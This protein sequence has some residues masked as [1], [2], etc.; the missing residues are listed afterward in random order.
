MGMKKLNQ[1]YEK[2]SMHRGLF[3]RLKD[4]WNSESNA[5]PLP[6]KSAAPAMPP[7][8][9]KQPEGEI[10]MGK[11]IVGGLIGGALAGPWGVAAGAIYG[12]GLG[13]K[14]SKMNK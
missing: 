5:K 14:I 1:L 3:S 2:Q 12:S 7:K 11:G 6:T 8:K 9:L 4:E 10:S 13:K